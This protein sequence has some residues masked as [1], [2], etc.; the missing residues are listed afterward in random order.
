MYMG[1]CGMSKDQKYWLAFNSFPKNVNKNGF[2]IMT[3]HIFPYIF[4]ITGSA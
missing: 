4:S 3:I 1:K 2:V